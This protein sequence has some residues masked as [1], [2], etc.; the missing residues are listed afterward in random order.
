MSYENISQL[1]TEIQE[2]LPQ[3]AQQ[4]FVAAFNAASSDGADED[5]AVQIAWNSV[6]NSFE[7]GEDGKW[8]HKQYGDFSPRGTSNMA[9]G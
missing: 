1:P 8:Q 2:K 6:K 3:G 5:G 4:I 9:N 7:E